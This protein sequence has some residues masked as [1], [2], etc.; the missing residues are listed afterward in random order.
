MLAKQGILPG[1]P[2]DD[3]WDITLN[4]IEHWYVKLSGKEWANLVAD[5]RLD[6]LIVEIVLEKEVTIDKLLTVLRAWEKSSIIEIIS[7]NLEEATTP[8][9]ILKLLKAAET[10]RKGIE[11]L[12]HIAL[13]ES[14]HIQI[15]LAYRCEEI[16]GKNPILVTLSNQKIL[17]FKIEDA[18]A[19][20]PQ[21]DRE[22]IRFYLTNYARKLSYEL[23]EDSTH[24]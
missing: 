24:S 1:R 16:L 18:M 5:G 8:V 3:G 10:G 21:R 19:E 6:P 9:L 7:H 4:N 23:Q 11:S 13:M 2:C 14:M 12:K 17:T 20:L 22:I 15:E